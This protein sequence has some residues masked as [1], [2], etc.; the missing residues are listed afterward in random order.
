VDDPRPLPGAE[1]DVR[2]LPKECYAENRAGV[3]LVVA[4]KLT[5]MG[6]GAGCDG[7]V[8]KIARDLCIVSA[9]EDVV[10]LLDTKAGLEDSARG[11]VTNLDQAIVVVDPTVAAMEIAAQ[12]KR[13]VEQIQAGEPPATAH[14]EDPQL[15]TLARRIFRDARIRRVLVVANRIEGTV[16]ERDLRNKLQQKNLTLTGVVYKDPLIAAAWLEG[17]ALKWTPFGH[18]LRHVVASLE[19]GATIYVG[20]RHERRMRRVGRG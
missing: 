9:T 1:F 13:T 2:A 20:G 19:S 8:A 18:Q 17:A 5:G 10:T 12:M 15:R 11:V 14:L 3:G 16:T 4:G 6:P 7:P